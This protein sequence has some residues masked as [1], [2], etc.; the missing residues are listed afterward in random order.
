MGHEALQGNAKV[1]ALP[2]SPSR[3]VQR[4]VGLGGLCLQRGLGEREKE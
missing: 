3:R 1:V 4:L 2:C